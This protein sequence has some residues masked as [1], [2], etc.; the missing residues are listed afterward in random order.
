M[1]AHESLLPLAVAFGMAYPTMHSISHES[2]WCKALQRVVV[3]CSV[4]SR[5]EWAQG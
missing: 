3:G 1:S 5:I 2:A 4:Y